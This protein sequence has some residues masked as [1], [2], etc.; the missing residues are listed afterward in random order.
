MVRC[1]PGGMNLSV[2]RGFARQEKSGIS[3]SAGCSPAPV[4]DL[5]AMGK[6][7]IYNH[8]DPHSSNSRNLNVCDHYTA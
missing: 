7:K 5:Y 8:A 1:F 2:K 3:V 4:T 6:L